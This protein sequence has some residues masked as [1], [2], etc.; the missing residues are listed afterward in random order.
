MAIEIVKLNISDY[1]K[2]SN[3]WN[4]QEQSELAQKIYRELLSG[5]RDTYIYKIDGEFVGEIS[6]LKETN[7]SDYTIPNKRVYVSRL[8]IKEEYRRQGIGKKLVG[9]II[10]KAKKM[11]YREMSIGVDLDNYPAL[12]LY[13]DYGFDKIIYMGEDKYGKFLKL[14]KVI[15]E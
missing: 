2:C 12:K 3:I 8:I 13:V 6:M 15:Q 4:M 11:G 14:L 7:D 5:N 10:D 1:Q 9:F